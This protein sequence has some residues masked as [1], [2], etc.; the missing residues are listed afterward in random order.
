MLKEEWQIQPA[1]QKQSCCFKTAPTLLSCALSFVRLS[2][3]LV[4]HQALALLLGGL[5]SASSLA[6]PLP[7]CLSLCILLSKQTASRTPPTSQ[8]RR[9]FASPAQSASYFECCMPFPAQMILNSPLSFIKVENSACQ[10][11][12][13]RVKRYQAALAL[14][15]RCRSKP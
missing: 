10:S 5:R 1:Q 13:S 9:C 2:L 15:D 7:S 11:C 4:V 14:R 8:K 3:L 6:Q 12:F